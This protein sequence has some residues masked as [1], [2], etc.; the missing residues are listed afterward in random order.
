MQHAASGEWLLNKSFW[1]PEYRQPLLN[2]QL[3]VCHVRYACGKPLY[4]DFH[5]LFWYIA[6]IIRCYWRCWHS[7]RQ[8]KLLPPCD[9]FHITQRRLFMS[10]ESPV[11]AFKDAT[12]RLGEETPAEDSNSSLLFGEIISL[13]SVIFR[14]QAF[15][16]I[17]LHKINSSCWGEV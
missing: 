14:R 13:I 11:G 5:P 3:T 1:Y 15:L 8:F 2:S 17:K 9:C 10:S 6:L 16:R 12:S 4:L 7:L